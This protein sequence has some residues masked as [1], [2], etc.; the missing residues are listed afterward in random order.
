MTTARSSQKVHRYQQVIGEFYGTPKEVWGFEVP[1]MRGTPVG[2]ARR[3]LEAN[4]GLLGLHGLR[5]R[6]EHART[7]F[8]LGAI[9]VLFRQ[10]HR[11]RSINR[12][13][14]TVHIGAGGT[15]YL[16]K[17]RAVPEAYLAKAKGAFVIGPKAARRRAHAA[18]RRLH[19]ALA[20][21]G[22]VE[23]V[24]FPKKKLL[25]AAYK[26]RVHGER[27]RSEWIIYVNAETGAILQRYDNLSQAT[28]MASVFD[29]NPVAV[30]A[31]WRDLAGPSGRVKRAPASAYR[32]VA[33]DNLDPGGR[34]D[35]PRVST[36]L[37]RKRVRRADYRFL[38]THDQAGFEEA[39]V[40]F[41]V[42]RAIAYLESLGYTGNRAIF[43][44][45]ARNRPLAANVRGTRDDN[46][47]YSP[48]TRSL[49]FGTGGVDD[50]EDGET[51][52][53]EFGHA[54]QDAI[55]PDFGQSEEAAAMG[56]GFGDYFAGSF[57]AAMKPEALRDRVMSWDAY[58]ISDF[59]PPALRR[60][61]EPLTSRAF[62]T[63]GDEHDNGMIWSAT[64]WDIWT[65]LGRDI[66][67][68]IIIES[69]FQLDGYT[70]FARGARAI[71]D[72]DR[73]LFGGAHA[74]RLRAIFRKRKI[75]L[76]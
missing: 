27:P 34:L 58:E 57:F 53:H 5:G 66:A 45:A 13:Y 40:Y 2:R 63:G 14:V 42:D 21:M 76:A 70:T 48:G 12:A 9:H 15:V 64:L 16:T 55:C 56:E 37:T 71:I 41:H 38:F 20:V 47:W 33:L 50:A 51:I 75:A 52:L 25:Y 11:G 30:A 17:N 28:G 49:T 43:S 32:M 22:K 61:D 68:R 8:S 24:W 3:F 60:L 62:R 23:E 73:N 6:L 29:P 74:A 1:A 54:V 7:V 39:M 18:V 4:I 26:V 19:G 67:D 44:A 10:R 46:S 65:A 69:H 31:D 35:G 59:K 36:R 72:A